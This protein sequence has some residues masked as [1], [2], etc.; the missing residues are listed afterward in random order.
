MR[1]LATSKARPVPNARIASDHKTYCKR[2]SVCAW[3]FAHLPAKGELLSASRPPQIACA[4]AASPPVNGH[5]AR[6]RCLF[7]VS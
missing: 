5:S 7:R 3:V 2:S 4:C 6:V 1:Q